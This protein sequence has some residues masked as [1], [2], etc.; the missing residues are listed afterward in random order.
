MFR[1]QLPWL[2]HHVLLKSRGFSSHF[3][4]FGEQLITTTAQVYSAGAVQTPPPSGPR[5]AWLHC[6]A[7]R[8]LPQKS[9]SQRPHGVVEAESHNATHEIGHCAQAVRKEKGQVTGTCEATPGTCDCRIVQRVVL[10]RI[11][12]AKGCTG[13]AR[14]V[15]GIYPPDASQLDLQA[16]AQSRTNAAKPVVGQAGAMTISL[17]R[18]NSTRMPQWHASDVDSQKAVNGASGSTRKQLT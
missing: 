6:D 4:V 9:R 12:A 3:S 2:I 5:Q 13:S 17:N 7:P 1:C 8:S 10:V 14:V 15:D 18:S 11:R 16:G